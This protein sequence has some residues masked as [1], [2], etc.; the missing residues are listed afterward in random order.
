MTK[1]NPDLSWPLL[2]AVSYNYLDDV[3]DLLEAGADPNAADSTGRSCLFYA[4][5]L[6]HGA[7]VCALLAAGASPIGRSDLFAPLAAAA[8]RGHVDLVRL[9]VR[10]GASVN[11]PAGDLTPLLNAAEGGQLVVVREL[12][13]LGADVNAVSVFGKRAIHGAIE[14][15]GTR[16]L[17]ARQVIHTLVEAGADVD[18]VDEDG[19]T[20][21]M[22]AAV[23]GCDSTTALLI[24]NGADVRRRNVYNETAADI[25]RRLGFADVAML[26]EDEP[27]HSELRSMAHKKA[28]RSA[29]SRPST[30]R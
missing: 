28:T 7:I 21:V 13:A 30:G 1:L 29:A 6:G 12:L 17:A 20:P 16:T 8:L 4:A 3:H 15:G 14:C 5:D 11:P 27:F 25:A 2:E 23:H 26:L 18:V 19:W 9:L 22:W 10:N 24:A